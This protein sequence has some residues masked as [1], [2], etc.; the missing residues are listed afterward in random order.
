M[1]TAMTRVERTKRT[2]LRLSIWLRTTGTK[3]ENFHAKLR[4]GTG[5][6]GIGVESAHY[7]SEC[8]V[9]GSAR[10]I[11]RVRSV[12]KLGAINR[13]PEIVLFIQFVEKRQWTVADGSKLDV[14]ITE[15][16][17]KRHHQETKN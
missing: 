17:G 15:R 14:A 12:K 13:S 16:R 7:K 11:W 3:G 10:K 9:Y 1:L 2:A 6:F 5:P 8:N 4:R